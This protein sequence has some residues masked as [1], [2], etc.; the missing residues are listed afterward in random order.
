LPTGQTWEPNQRFNLFHIDSNEVHLDS[1]KVQI[2]NPNLKILEP[3]LLHV[4]SR[5][6]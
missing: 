3:G 6:V 2:F 5:S 1:V 4:C